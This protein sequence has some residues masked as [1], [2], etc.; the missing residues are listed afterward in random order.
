MKLFAM[1]AQEQRAINY[2]LDR[3]AIQQ[4]DFSVYCPSC[5]DTDTLEAVDRN[6]FM[7]DAQVKVRASTDIF[8][9][10]D[11]L[12]CLSEK[13]KNLLQQM[14]ESVRYVKL[15]NDPYWVVMPDFVIELDV[16]RVDPKWFSRIDHGCDCLRIA[17]AYRAVHEAL[18]IGEEDLTDDAIYTTDP[19]TRAP[20]ILC[21]ESVKDAIKSAKLRGSD[22]YQI[23]L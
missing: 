15:P 18:E 14:V 12:L 8:E 20:T 17:G 2:V 22:F 6:M 9:T 3:K 13:A 5:E 7:P 23:R 11:H 21:T 16:D 4:A 1:L 10:N 19:Y